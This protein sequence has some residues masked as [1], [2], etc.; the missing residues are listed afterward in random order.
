MSNTGNVTLT[1]VALSDDNDNNDASCATTTL[2]PGATTSCSATHT[3]SQAELDAGFGS[4]NP[5]P[6]NCGTG[7]YNFVEV[8]STE[9]ATDDDDLCIP[10][11]QTPLDHG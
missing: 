1:G 4:V 11:V 7:L 8:D 5:N 9:N 6:V 3:F 2:A 10:I